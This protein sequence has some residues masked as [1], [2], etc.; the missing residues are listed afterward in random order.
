MKTIASLAAIAAA[1]SAQQFVLYSGADSDS[2]QRADPIITP[3]EISGHVHD[4]LG[5][6]AFKPELSYQA[7]QNKGCTSVG[8]AAGDMVEADSSVYWHPS[9]Y[10]KSKKT[11]GFI[12]VPTTSHKMYYRKVSDQMQEFPSDND[13]RMVAG[14]PFK[15]SPYTD[16]NNLT[17]WT[18]VRDEYSGDPNVNGVNGAFPKLDRG[19]NPNVGLMGKIHFPHCYMRN[20]TKKD[21][22]NRD[23]TAYPEG[24]PE[25]GTCPDTHPIVLP[26]IFME[27]V[28]NVNDDDIDL[29]SFTLAQG[30]S[31][32]YGW[33]ADFFNGWKEGA[34]SK[35][36]SDCPAGQYGNHD[37]ADCASYSPSGKSTSGCKLQKYF[38]EDVESPGANL[39]GCN[40]VSLLDP[41]PKLL[42]AAL[43]LSESSCGSADGSSGSGSS[44]GG[45]SYESPSSASTPESSAGPILSIPTAYSAPAPST[46]F[47]VST[48]S[49]A[50]APAPSYDAPVE[51]EGDDDEDTVWVTDWVEAYATATETVYA[52]R[53]S[54]QHNHLAKHKRRHL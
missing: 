34:I 43:G 44:S 13:F 40:P 19:C 4:F 16:G 37:I 18:C 31:T 48:T 33:H 42:V 38:K 6:D 8:S 1:A 51:E 46:T 47:A 54:H 10:A 21:I 22:D 14:D 30:D 27:N 15:R 50:W 25:T 53:D 28:F 45:N 36:Y 17:Q 39:I 20:P 41:A 5:A 29:N 7:L 11:G 3:G 12:K 23:H 52:K 9:L 32:G 24:H 26:H 2:A 35:L 49:A